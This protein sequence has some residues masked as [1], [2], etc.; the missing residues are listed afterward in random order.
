M[1]IVG[2]ICGTLPNCLSQPSIKLPLISST[3][4]PRSY[5]KPITSNF[6]VIGRIILD[7]FS[8]HVSI[9]LYFFLTIGLFIPVFSLVGAS[10]IQ[11]DAWLLEF[12]FGYWF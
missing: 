7:A 4:Q 6:P 3:S 5:L 1:S 9:S 12:Q 8:L 10:Y 2:T 11:K